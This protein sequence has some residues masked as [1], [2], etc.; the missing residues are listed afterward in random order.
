MPNLNDPTTK[1]FLTNYINSIYG[2][3]SQ[4]TRDILSGLFGQGYESPLKNTEFLSNYLKGALTTGLPYKDQFRQ[5]STGTINRS[6]DKASTNLKEMFAGKGT[7]RGGASSAAQID[8][9][10]QRGGAL[11]QNEANLNLQDI[12][13][14][15]GAIAKLLG[16]EQLNLS[17]AGLNQNFLQSL[18]G[19][20][21]AA[22]VN[23]FNID[24][25]KGDFWDLLPG[26]IQGGSNIIA[27][28]A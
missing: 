3:E 16:L 1:L 26:L 10:G 22:D 19:G 2:G 8:L 11:A 9:A 14:R 28:A 5:E 24:Q 17:E 20:K 4:Q 21:N 27:A 18:I 6:Y 7:Y 12:N 23:N 25:S 13:F 15:E